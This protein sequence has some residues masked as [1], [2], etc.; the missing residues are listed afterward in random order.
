MQVRPSS[1]F[2]TLL[3]LALLSIPASHATAA[4]QHG[5]YRVQAQI[6]PR[7]GD[8]QVVL[9]MAVRPDAGAR[10]LSF[11]LHGDLAV[12]SLEG[13]TLEAFEVAPYEWPG[14][15]HLQHIAQVTVNLQE[16]AAE[17][18]PVSLQWRYGGTMQ[19]DHIE[20][21]QAAM[22][23]HWMELPA[24]ALWVPMLPDPSKQFTWEATVELP[25]GYRLVAAGEETRH[26]T[27]WELASN[28]PSIDI[29]LIASDRMQSR[30][31]LV[32]GGITVNVHH[33]GS[34]KAL[35]DYVTRHAT[36]IVGR[37][38]AR[39]RADLHAP[40][41]DIALSPLQRDTAH[42]YARPGLIGLF[43]GMEPG[44]KLFRLLAHEAAHLW[45]MN[46]SDGWSRHNFLSESFAEYFAWVELGREY[47]QAHYDEQVANARKATADAPSFNEWTQ[48]NNG[49][50]SYVKGPLLL[51]ELHERIGTEDFDRFAQALQANRIGTI[52]DMVDTLAALA[53]AEHAAWFN[54]KL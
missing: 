50:L 17:G 27:R 2:S 18:Q 40:E 12:Q 4:T 31:A 24:E 9:D 32:D 28:K 20:M 44:P 38:R 5:H 49:L 8:M 46:A 45:W 41:L 37:Y 36:G 39:F 34:D 29:A 48:E 16:P 53:G 14:A 10:E 19:D 25:E 13:D 33:G 54:G 21:G 1:R 42:A 43:S 35:V 26:G 52:E 23:P 11:L 15:P 3:L 47:G 6:D 7:S 51:H 30:E 22:T